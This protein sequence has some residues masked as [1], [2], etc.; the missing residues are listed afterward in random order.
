VGCDSIELTATIG[1]LG[2]HRLAHR[3]SVC[4]RTDWCVSDGAMVWWRLFIETVAFGITYSFFI[5]H[6]CV[7]L[8]VQE[9]GCGYC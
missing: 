7:V 5:S 3:S 9:V 4:G 1:L 8:L 6:D 2:P